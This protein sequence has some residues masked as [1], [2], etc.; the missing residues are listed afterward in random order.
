MNY[1]MICYVLSL[2]HA[3]EA[4]LMTLPLAVTLYYHEDPF[5]FLVA[6]LVTLAAAGI[7]FAFRPKSR[8]LFAREGFVAVALSWVMMSL[9]GALPFTISGWIPSYVDAV[10]ETVSGFTTTGASIL[11]DI[12]ALP[13]GL[14]F[15][16]SLTH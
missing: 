10:F 9:F 16:R 7:L 11:V 14:L 8:V 15:W 5:A 2:V 13:R 4:G 12:E 3:I 1:R 6:I